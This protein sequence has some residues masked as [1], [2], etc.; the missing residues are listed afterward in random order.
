MSK[1]RYVFTLN[2]VKI[3][4]VDQKY[5][6]VPFGSVTEDDVI[7]PNATKID[8]L[9]IVKRTPEIISFLDESK[10]LRKC[11]VSMIDFQ[12]EK[13]CGEIVKKNKCKYKCFWDRNNI[14]ENI[15]PIGCPIKYVPSKIT[16]SY[17][18]EISKEK[19]TIVENVT[20]KKAK[21]LKIKKD[22]RIAIEQKS[23]YQTDGIFCS[24]N[25]CMAY[26]QAPENKHNS[27]YRHS[28]SLLLKMYNDLN[29]DEKMVEI[30]SAPHWRTLEE[31]GG[32][33]NI[34]QFRES[35][36][37]VNYVDHGIVCVSIGRLYED[38]LKF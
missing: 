31:F 23:Y 10:M 2:G 1:K 37:K 35:F 34:E 29:P 36:N 4:K 13:Q 19:Y 16:K 22:P 32:Y 12:S 24:F 27:L 8:D 5:G 25:C 33:L 26:I 38:Q 28:A 3:N 6:I 20:D 17:H 15:Q 18:S 11:T 14:P 7:P 30:A 21:N 9:D